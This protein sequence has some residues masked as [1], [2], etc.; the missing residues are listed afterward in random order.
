MSNEIIKKK[1]G[2]MIIDGAIKIYDLEENLDLEFPDDR[3]YD[4]LAG[5]ILD[6]V[7]DIPNK[8]SEVSFKN[9]KFKVI[10][11]D[12][13]RIDKVEVIIKSE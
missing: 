12:S 9:Y 2:N 6:S 3:E 10:T 7:G 4:T 8:G 11:L 13:N 1:D 5:Y